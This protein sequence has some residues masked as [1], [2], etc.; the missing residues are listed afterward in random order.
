MA[1]FKNITKMEMT[2]LGSEHFETVILKLWLILHVNKGQVLSV[3]HCL[4]YSS[5]NQVN[6]CEIRANNHSFFSSLFWK[7]ERTF[8]QNWTSVLRQDKEAEGDLV[9][10]TSPGIPPGWNSLMETWVFFD[11]TFIWTHLKLRVLQMFFVFWGSRFRL[12]LEV[13]VLH[14]TADSVLKV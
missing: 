6:N 11:P 5:V 3:S 10:K 1:A 8:D 9:P 14:L 13:N 4:C 2:T 7:T 12:W